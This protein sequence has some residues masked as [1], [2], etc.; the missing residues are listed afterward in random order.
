ML[1]K[2]DA[3]E[4]DNEVR[5][6]KLLEYCVQYKDWIKYTKTNCH[7]PSGDV[8]CCLPDGYELPASL[9]ND[10][11][12]ERF[13]QMTRLIKNT[14]DAKKVKLCHKTLVLLQLT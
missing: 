5:E 14:A 10:E 2:L 3:Y 8:K 1:K 9:S 11:M 13:K 7:Y 6:A 4:V 12:D